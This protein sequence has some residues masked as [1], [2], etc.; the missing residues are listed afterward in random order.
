M[1]KIRTS[2]KFHGGDHYTADRIVKLVPPHITKYHEGCAGSLAVLFARRPPYGSEVVND[3]NGCITNFWRV[4]QRPDKFALFHRAAAFIPVN[5]EEWRQHHA[6]RV[7]RKHWRLTDVTPDWP[8]TITGDPEVDR[9]LSFFVDC[10]QSM[11]ARMKNFVRDTARLRRQMN[12][13]V[14]AWLSG[15]EGLLDCHERM[16]SVLIHNDE[17]VNSIRATD[18]EDTLHYIDPPF[19]STTR[20]APEVYE[21]EMTAAQ[22]EELLR[23]VCSCSGKVILAGYDSELYRD[24][25]KDWHCVNFTQPNHSAKRAT[26]ALR[27]EL[28]WLNYQPAS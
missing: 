12:E 5:Q 14:S 16:M 20:T 7:V 28:H 19:L 6:A 21:C 17:V 9:A 15:V 26:K 23:C 11:S 1:G 8:L 18:G 2:L 3:R 24:Y 25:L 4:M 10:R 22:H 13:H 27:N